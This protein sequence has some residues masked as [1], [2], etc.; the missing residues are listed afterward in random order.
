MAE[1]VEPTVDIAN[2]AFHDVWEAPAPLPRASLA[3]LTRHLLEIG[4]V[5]ASE[6]HRAGLLANDAGMS[7]AVA[8]VTLGDGR[9]FVVKELLESADASQ[10]SPDQE[11][12]IYRLAARV[13][14]LATFLAPVVDLGDGRPF[15]VLALQNDESVAS[16]AART[17]WSDGELGQFLGHA[18]GTWHE[19]SRPHAED[20]TPLPV[21]WVLR[22]IGPD[23]PTFLLSNVHVVAFLDS[24][25]ASTLARGLA[26]GAALWRASGVVHGDLRFDNC[27][28]DP[29][30]RTTF[31][32][33]ECGGLG[34][35]LWDVAT[36]LQELILRLISSRCDGLRAGPHGR[37]AAHARGVPGLLPVGGLG[38]RT[39]PTRPLHGGPPAPARVP[40]CGARPVRADRGAGSS[41]RAGGGAVI[42]A[43]RLRRSHS[44]PAGRSPP[45]PGRCGCCGVIADR[46]MPLPPSPSAGVMDDLAALAAQLRTAPD[47]PPD[48]VALSGGAFVASERAEVKEGATGVQESSRE[49]IDR[50]GEPNDRPAVVDPHRTGSSTAE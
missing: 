36:I 1:R 19:L 28:I 10:G 18:L 35:P 5:S 47:V 27:L 24:L 3:R 22:A 48:A 40:A 30:G 42:R 37:G 17:G 11:R 20:L 39:H 32:D 7:H 21:P 9:G 45:R 14:T 6:V 26:D 2:R 4:L 23:R 50:C 49:T 34:D 33:W 44:D 12:G 31:V 38:G 13:P 16:R 15:I 43:G 8:V 46:P 41:S 29:H 25:D